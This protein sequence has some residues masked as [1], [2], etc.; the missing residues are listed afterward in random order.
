M[1]KVL[2]FGM[3]VCEE[4]HNGVVRPEDT[5]ILVTECGYLLAMIVLIEFEV[6]FSLCLMNFVIFQEI[7]L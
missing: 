5:V 4:E 1:W 6:I 3:R 2:K 7:W